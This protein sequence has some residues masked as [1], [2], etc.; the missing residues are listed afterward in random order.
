MLKRSGCL[1][2]HYASYF[3]CMHNSTHTCQ[4]V[5][6]GAKH[7]QCW[8]TLAMHQPEKINTRRKKKQQHF[9]P[10]IIHFSHFN[11]KGQN[12]INK[13]KTS[14]LKKMEALLIIPCFSQ[15]CGLFLKIFLCVQSGG[16]H[17][18]NTVLIYSWFG[19]R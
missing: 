8:F 3:T 17:C 11:S 16:V 7:K 5:L 10:I 2:L 1:R 6:N 18:R 12:A 13:Q 15:V 19:S 4:P 9:I 14:Y